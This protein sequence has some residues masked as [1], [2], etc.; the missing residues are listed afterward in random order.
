MSKLST[1]LQELCAKQE[2]FPVATADK[3]GLPNVVP[4]TFVRVYDEEHLLIV[5]NFMNKTRKN[6]EANSVMAVCVWDLKNGKSYQ[7]K[8]KTTLSASGPVFDKA[9]AWVKE[10]MPVL[11]PK[12]AVLMKVE[13]IF[14]CQPGDDLGK[15][16]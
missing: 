10:K 8:G 6:L 7:I 5:D 4:I 16:V 12:A 14:V 13:K 11:E 3:D 15:E 1:D 9:R 2:V